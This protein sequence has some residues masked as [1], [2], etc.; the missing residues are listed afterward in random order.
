MLPM[1]ADLQ[2]LM[3]TLGE[4]KHIT[5]KNYAA[6]TYLRFLKPQQYWWFKDEKTTYERAKKRSNMTVDWT[7][8]VRYL[9]KL[10]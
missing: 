4:I 8:K 5:G 2:E 1:K 9:V 6:V 3:I 7:K 10:P